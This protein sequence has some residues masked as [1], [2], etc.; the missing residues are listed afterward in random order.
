MPASPILA[1]SS[2]EHSQVSLK[3]SP[4][5]QLKALRIRQRM[6]IRSQADTGE[7]GLESAEI[8]SKV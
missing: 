5:N 7:L 6:R 3:T 8:E 4:R 2:I 1:L